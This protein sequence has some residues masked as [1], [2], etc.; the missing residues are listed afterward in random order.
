MTRQPY[1]G[2]AEQSQ[3]AKDVRKLYPCLGQLPEPRVSPP[4]V[5]LSGLPGTGKSYFCRRLTEK[6]PL[7]VVASDVFRKVLFP[8]P[9]YSGEESHRLF[10]ACYL[11][12][13]NLLYQGIPVVLDAT[14]LE[15]RHRERLYHIVDKVAA[16]LI[17][18]R[19]EAPPEVVQERLEK[20]S[21]QANSAEAG[22]EIYRRM[23]SNTQKIRR[24][25]FVV[26]TSQDISPVVNRV[27]REINRF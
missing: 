25:H 27:I 26:D 18:V 1:Q 17:I 6:L 2:E 5:V 22:W 20:R 11:L 21:T 8:S 7:T 4:L 16:R 9:C 15:E 24:N 23:K 13:E 12:I 14:N 19:I 3:L 10:E